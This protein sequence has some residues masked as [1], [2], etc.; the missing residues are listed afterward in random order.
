MDILQKIFS[1]GNPDNYEQRAQRY[2]TGY[3]NNQYDNIDDADVRD[4]YQRTLEYAPPDVL[5]QAHAEAFSRLSPQQRAEVLQRFQEANNDPT[6]PFQSDQFTGGPQDTDPRVMGRIA[7]QAAQQQPDLLQQVL[8]P[9][10][11]LSNPLAKAALAGVAA[12]AAQRMMGGGR[13][14][15]NRGGGLLGGPIV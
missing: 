7:R 8:G 14:G 12:M 1:G 4:R 15:G 10:G 9:G 5:E 11:V 2:N 6:Q 3:T 13:G